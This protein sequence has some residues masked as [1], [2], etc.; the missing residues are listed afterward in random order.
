MSAPGTDISPGKPP[1]GTTERERLKIPVFVFAREAIIGVT[2]PW[3]GFEML[4]YY[5]LGASIRIISVILRAYKRR[6]PFDVSVT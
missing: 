1:V 4:I 2:S 5:R 6:V 3:R